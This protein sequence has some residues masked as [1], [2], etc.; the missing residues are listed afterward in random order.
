MREEELQL[1]SLRLQPNTNTL[2]ASGFTTTEPV[3]PE[4]PPSSRFQT[5]PKASCRKPD[6]LSSQGLPGNLDSSKKPPLPA[7][8][9]LERPSL[10]APFHPWKHSLG[11]TSMW[12]TV[13]RSNVGSRR[14]WGRRP[15]SLSPLLLGTLHT[16]FS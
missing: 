15:L 14:G 6:G 2:P 4:G 9:E 1:E 7:S 3:S 5:R 10:A 11:D 12:T 13:L 8:Q 16:H